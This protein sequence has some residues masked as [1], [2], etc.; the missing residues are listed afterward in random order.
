MFREVN[1][2]LVDGAL[3]RE[4]DMWNGTRRLSGSFTEPTGGDV[5]LP[6][7]L[8]VHGLG[9]DQSGYRSR[10]VATTVGLS[11]VCL[12]FDLSNHG[13]S[14][15]LPS[16]SIRDH[17]GDV[18]HAYDVLAAHP[19]VGAT[20]I[21]ACGASYGGYL[22][23]RAAA[24][25]PIRRLL[26]RAPGLY[27]DDADDVVAALLKS[28]PV[29]DA[30]LMLSALRLSHTETLILESGHDEVI[31]AAVI[32]AYLNSSELMQH[33]SIPEATHA[34]IEPEWNHA[35]VDAIVSWFGAL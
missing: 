14:D 24:I 5:D 2:V 18:V 27:G 26:L 10:A 4:F 17:L 30:S 23:A 1:G 33:L 13:S 8:F 3:V 19:R 15:R 6:A 9:S 35:F 16:A 29:P 12:T 11:S 32:E 22:S 7:V 25:R 20:R 28:R 34:L 31:P 21:G